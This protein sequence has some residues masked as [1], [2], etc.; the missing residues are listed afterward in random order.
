M[1]EGYIVKLNPSSRW[2]NKL[3]VNPLDTEGVIT[4]FSTMKLSIEVKWSNGTSNNYDEVDL[5][6]VS[7]PKGE[8]VFNFTKVSM[9]NRVLVDITEHGS[10]TV[11]SMRSDRTYARLNSNGEPDG[12]C[13]LARD[14]RVRSR[15]AEVELFDVLKHKSIIEERFN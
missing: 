9:L 12:F 3:D 15:K 11:Y 10:G 7:K 4:K 5:I 2:N 8:N 13:V 6:V 14:M 1:I